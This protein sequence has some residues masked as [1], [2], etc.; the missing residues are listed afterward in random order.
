MWRIHSFQASIIIILGLWLIFR[1][2][3]KIFPRKCVTLNSSLFFSPSVL[4]IQKTYRENATDFNLGRKELQT[5]LKVSSKNFANNGLYWLQFL[6]LLR[7]RTKHNFLFLSNFFCSFEIHLQIHTSLFVGLYNLF[8]SDIRIGNLD[9][10]CH[11][12]A[13]FCLFLWFFTF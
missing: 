8:D 12:V 4:A 1:P 13:W 6:N 3:R 9:F 7:A 10:I 11:V 2:T 5:N